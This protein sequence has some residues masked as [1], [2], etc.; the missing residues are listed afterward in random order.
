LTAS[1]GIAVYPDDGETSEALLDRADG[2]MYRAKR[3]GGDRFELAATADR[4][5]A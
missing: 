3:N 1:I 4:T 5:A 2:A